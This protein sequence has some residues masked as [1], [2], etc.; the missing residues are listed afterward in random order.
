MGPVK[1]ALQRI[2]E[3]SIARAI[4]MG[5]ARAADLRRP[6]P[7]SLAPGRPLAGQCGSAPAPAC[8]S[9]FAPCLWPALP[10]PYQSTLQAIHPPHGHGAFTHGA[11]THTNL[12]KT[13]FYTHTHTHSF[14]IHPPPRAQRSALEQY[15]RDEGLTAMEEEEDLWT[16]GGDGLSPEQNNS[17]GLLGEEGG[18]GRRAVHEEM[19]QARAPPLTPP[20]LPLLTRTPVISRRCVFFLFFCHHLFPGW[21]LHLWL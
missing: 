4:A 18:A 8:L 7:A 20:L 19:S 5:G 21:S 12:Y 3:V 1:E 10:P 9:D 17:S 13:S 14:Y 11:F 6:A 15:E 16:E 2:Y